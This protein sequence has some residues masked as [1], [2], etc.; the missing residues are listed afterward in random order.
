MARIDT[1]TTD[2]AVLEELGSRLRALRTGSRRLTQDELAYRAGVSV[3]TVRRIEAGDAVRFDLVIRV[4]RTLGLLD[5]LD[6]LAPA[7]D[8][9]NPL[10]LLARRQGA[11]QRVRKRKGER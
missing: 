9:P 5:R 1:T 2:A 7:E 3:D 6:S 11:P 4:L 8:E 10:D